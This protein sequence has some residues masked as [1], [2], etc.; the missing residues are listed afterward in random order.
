MVAINTPLRV[1][2]I[3]NNEPGTQFW[4][5]IKHSFI[6]SFNIV[7]NDAK[8]SFFDPVEQGVLP[9]QAEF[10][11]IILSGGK[12]DATASDPWIIRELDYVKAT[13]NKDCKAKLMGICWG[14]QLIHRALGGDVGPVSGGPVVSLTVGKCGYCV[15]A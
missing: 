6:E 8:F 7:C 3:I 13:V 1:A 4:H 5:E 11:L 14:H 12:A 10:D 2:V 9:N 15:H